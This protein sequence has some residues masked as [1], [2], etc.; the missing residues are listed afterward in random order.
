MLNGYRVLDLTDERGD[1]AG[2]VLGDL[3]AD[4]IKVEPPGGSPSRR[5]GL[6]VEA[7]PESESSLNFFA[8][9]VAP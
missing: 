8:Y 4:V 9:N 6:T 3:G 2:M 5:R 7:A 1:I